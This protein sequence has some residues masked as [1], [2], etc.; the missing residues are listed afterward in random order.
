M[1]L[2]CNTGRAHTTTQPSPH[3]KYTVFICI[4]AKLDMHSKH[5]PVLAAIVPWFC[6]LIL[7]RH[8]KMWTDVILSSKGWNR[9]LL[10]HIWKK[11]LVLV[12]SFIKPGKKK[13]VLTR[14]SFMSL[15][16]L[17]FV[18]LKAILNVLSLLI[19]VIWFFFMPLVQSYSICTCM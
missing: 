17:C 15:G 16:F 10:S 2:A 12:V 3:Y 9:A 13:Q 14:N 11:L 7:D 1:S 18:C 8:M 6:Y 4:F 19:N 5:K